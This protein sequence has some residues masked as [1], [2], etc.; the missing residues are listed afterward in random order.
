[1]ELL[2]V[3]SLLQNLMKVIPALAELMLCLT[4]LHRHHEQYSQASVYTQPYLGQNLLN[5][6]T[7]GLIGTQYVFPNVQ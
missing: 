1:M 7:V 4:H 6:Y 5:G 2:N 3:D